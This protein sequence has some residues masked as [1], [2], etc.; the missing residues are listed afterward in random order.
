MKT[1]LYIT[2]AM[3]LFIVPALVFYRSNSIHQNVIYN[4]SILDTKDQ[5][6]KPQNYFITR[7]DALNQ[8]YTLFLEG[9]GINLRSSEITM[10]INLYKDMEHKN[11]YNW[12]VSWYNKKTMESYTCTISAS[13][14]KVINLF[15]VEER[16][17]FPTLEEE[18]KAY[19]SKEVQEVVQRFLSVLGKD[20]A[21]YQITEV[22]PQYSYEHYY[23][24]YLFINKEDEKD[25]FYMEIDMSQKLIISYEI[26]PGD[27]K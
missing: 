3:L 11:S 16:E 10:Y 13:E 6:E 26:D 15:V 22:D 21:E 8:A 27:E 1:K 20:E 4:V 24:K 17:I 2:L 12:L 18:K 5:K 14:D 23:N 7:V 19:S 9:L 25:K